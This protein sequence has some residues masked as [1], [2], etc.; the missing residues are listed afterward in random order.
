MNLDRVVKR[1]EKLLIDQSND[2]EELKSQHKNDVRNLED[3]HRKRMFDIMEEFD[4]DKDQ[5][6]LA[7]H[8][9]RG[10]IKKQL[11]KGAN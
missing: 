1:M 5:A 9:A 11:T 7:F 4:I 8:Q 6:F 2:I 3:S 10:N